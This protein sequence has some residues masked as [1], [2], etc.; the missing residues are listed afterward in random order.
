M[1]CVYNYKSK[2]NIISKMST[3]NHHSLT[4]YAIHIIVP[5]H[6]SPLE[7]KRCSRA[8][9]GQ[10]HRGSKGSKTC[11]CLC[12]VMKPTA[13]KP[14]SREPILSGVIPGCPVVPGWAFRFPELHGQR[15]K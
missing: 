14:G 13:L 7:L 6:E 11:H 9:E 5:A 3:E 8:A 2:Y 15:A 10:L 4:A 1:L 12:L